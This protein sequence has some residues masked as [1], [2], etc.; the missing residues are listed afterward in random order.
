MSGVAVSIVQARALL[1]SSEDEIF[2][3]RCGFL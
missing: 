2:R 1:S 3:H